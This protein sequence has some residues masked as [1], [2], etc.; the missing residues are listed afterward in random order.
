MI[1]YL[2]DHPEASIPE[3]CKTR[4]MTKA[5][6]RFFANPRDPG[7]HPGSPSR[8]NRAAGGGVPRH[9]GCSGYDGLQFHPPS[10]DTRIGA[11]W[12]S[13]A[14]GVLPALLPGGGVDQGRIE[15]R[16]GRPRR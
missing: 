14:V 4:S 1:E 15:T 10:P 2:S 7:R 5:A 6:Y 13:W 12:P 8:G 3:A 16:R 9:S 11:H